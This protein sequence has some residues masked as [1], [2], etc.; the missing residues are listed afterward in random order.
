MRTNYPP[1]RYIYIYIRGI[2]FFS[3]G[4]VV[5]LLHKVC[6]PIARPS[7]AM[8]GLR[9]KTKNMDLNSCSDTCLEEALVIAVLP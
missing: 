5:A 9:K 2:I 3:K 8:S 6:M 4:H 1:Y 7:A